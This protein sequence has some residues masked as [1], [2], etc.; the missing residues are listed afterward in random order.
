[1]FSRDLLTSRCLVS[2]SDLI[3]TVI[4]RVNFSNDAMNEKINAH[5]TFIA[6][7]IAGLAND[8]GVTGIAYDCSLLDV[9]VANNDG[10]TDGLKVAKGIIWAADH[11]A[12]VITSVS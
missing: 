1:M 2:H 5:G 10:S 3:G 8:Y 9:K 12:N 6:G 11:G 4:D 7:M